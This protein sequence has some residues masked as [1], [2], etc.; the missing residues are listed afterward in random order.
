MKKNLLLYFAWLSFCHR[1]HG[2]HFYVPT[3][4]WATWI[5]DR[6]QNSQ[7]HTPKAQPENMMVSQVRN[8]GFHDWLSRII[9]S[10]QGERWLANCRTGGCFICGPK[11]APPWQWPYLR[12]KSSG[13]NLTWVGE[14]PPIMT[15]P[16]PWGLKDPFKWN[17]KRCRGGATPEFSTGVRP[18]KCRKFI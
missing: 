1:L 9:P 2:F 15:M 3:G 16:D 8:P 17:A 11:N 14:T 13:L 5:T 10:L 4:R 7:V 18:G 6:W 12:S